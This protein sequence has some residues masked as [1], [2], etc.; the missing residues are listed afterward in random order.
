[1]GAA[2]AVV[3]L[4]FL[5]GSQA[6]IPGP[7]PFAL[8][9][10]AAAS[11]AGAP[12]YAGALGSPRAPG[13]LTAKRPPGPGPG[14]IAPPA[15]PLLSRR[16]ERARSFPHRVGSVR[17]RPWVSG[18]RAPLLAPS[19]ASGRLE[20]TVPFAGVPETLRV[21]GLRI[22]F[23]TDRLGAQTSTPD[24]RFD[25]RDGDSLGIPIDPPPHDRAYFASHLEALSRYWRFVSYGNL[26]VEYDVY[27]K[28]DTLTYRLGDTG[29]YGPWTLGQASFDEAARFFK[30]AVQEADQTDSIPFGDFDVVTLFHAGADFQTDL[31]GDSP[32][33]FPTFQ[34]TLE[35]SVLVNGGAV[36]VFG[37]M[38]MP[39]TENQ[40]G[41][42]AAL[43]GTLAH[44]FGHTQGLP[45]L[46]D[47]NTFF[48]AVG[49]WSNMDSGY[50]LTTLVQ[51]QKTG[52]IS[53]A[54][55][56]IPTS[57]D[58]WC[59]TN[60]W[61]DKLQFVDPGRSYTGRLRATELS[62]SI[63]Y[64]PLGGDE[65]YL[66]ENREAD[67]NRDGT[68]YLDRDSTT[69]VILGPGLSSDDPA[70]SLGDREW[71]FLLPGEGIL[72]WHIDDTVIFGANIPPDFGI[73]SNP[74]RRGV[75]VVEADG[76]EDIG[77]PY[78]RWFF[79]SPYDPWFVGNRTRLGP[80]TSPSTAT[81]SGAQSHVSITVGSPPGIGMDLQ[82]G[83]DW[84]AL[85]WPVFTEFGSS[86]DPPTYGS[87]R[88][89]GNRNVVSSADSLILAWM[90]DGES[91]LTS[92]TNGRFA[93]LPAP[94]VSPVLFADSLFRQ[95]ALSNHGAAV[96]ATAMD[97]NVYA[98]RAVTRDTT[99][100]TLLTGWPPALGAGVTA[101]TAPVL[102]P[103]REVLVG[104]SDGRIFAIASPD[105]ADFPPLVSP[106][107]DTLVVGATPVTAPVV[108][109]LAVGRFRGPP[110]GYLV[111]YAL[112]NGVVRLVS[113]AGKDPIVTDLHWNVGGAAFRPYI[114]G[115]DLDR[116]ADGNLEV[117]VVDQGQ[118]VVHALDLTGAELP[119]WPV[120]VTAGLHGAAGAGDLDGDGYPEVFAVDDQGFAHRWNRNGVEPAGWPVS[121]AGRYGPDALGGSGSPAIGDLDGDG[122]SE[123]LVATRNG[124]LI[125]LEDDARALPGWPLAA[126][127]G[128]EI[129][130]LLLSL[131]DARTPPDPAG[132]AWQHVV[133]AGGDGLWSAFQVGARADSAF[134][135]RDGTSRRTPW[136]GYGGNRRRTSVMD[137]AD[138]RPIALLPTGLARGSL[139]CYPN[140]ARGADVG[141]AYTLG[142]G[143]GSVDIRILDPLGNEVRRLAGSTSP[144]E[145]VARIPVLDLASGVYLVRLEVKRGGATEV[146]FRKFAVVR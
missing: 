28:S 137:D 82:I 47:I 108:G 94:I 54:S 138:L 63:L 36:A 125:A 14:T 19:L 88:H 103:L 45:D 79:G 89:D 4:G 118:G 53:E 72:V 97:G 38:V 76:I 101:T 37:G 8:P 141:V 129:S 22:D 44:E 75:A 87:L 13:R 69:G 114:L 3:M 52:Q 17:R 134:A 92:N 144:A 5:A 107:S 65:Y 139:Y 124:M 12:S 29:D 50:L 111:A 143:V 146:A 56:V 85:G 67:L 96:V 83:S 35:D 136:I 123:A 21:L 10:A 86:G 24:G 26:V 43:N 116:S 7:A 6:L 33:D 41:Y 48:P 55:G 132:P 40:D 66:L 131:N 122:A 127:P 30:E 57:L 80:D 105:R 34:I 68:V 110:G 81:N 49:I 9:P 62:D 119:G 20:R 99:D 100:A 112:S 95:D 126:Q 15:G 113:P 142:D 61:P 115:V 25:L 106:I 98:Y 18:G 73:N 42:L 133:A 46:Y 130:P 58:P 117:I 59:K 2:R 78:S 32:R 84:R 51:D 16:I 91:Y 140:P 145:N 77:D 71:D 128:D 74:E 31:A 27:P 60:L 93:E 1:M 90:S 39:E 121:L 64:V 135:T 120:G 109:N 102:A 70:D 23:E 11:A 104:G